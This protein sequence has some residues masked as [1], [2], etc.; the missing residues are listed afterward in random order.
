ML[1]I[2]DRIVDGEDLS[3][4]MHK[5]TC[6]GWSGSSLRISPLYLCS[7]CPYRSTVYLGLWF[8]R[9]FFHPGGEPMKEQFCPWW[10]DSVAIHTTLEQ[11][12][13]GARGP[14]QKPQMV[15]AIQRP[16]MVTCFL[17]LA[18]ISG[19][20]HSLHKWLCELGNTCSKHKNQN[21]MNGFN[22]WGDFLPFLPRILPLPDL[23]GFS[24][25]EPDLVFHIPWSSG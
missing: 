2:K 24:K 9:D 19:S 25:C 21:N 17:Q 13:A 8:Q 10:Q 11:E 14:V 6:V 23:Y 12:T 18:A 7:C 15:P 20:F 4:M 3:G 5:H 22:F 1:I 16:P